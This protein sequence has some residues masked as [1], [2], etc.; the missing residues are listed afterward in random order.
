MLLELW[1]LLEA[2]FFLV[3]CVVQRGLCRSAPD[4][5]ALGTREARRETLERVLAV[6]ESLENYSFSDFVSGWFLGADAD[7][8][9]RG[10]LR[11][12]VAWALFAR[13]A[14]R[15]SAAEREECESLVDACA[16]LRARE[17]PCAPLEDADRGLPHV[18]MTIAPLHF[19]HRP[20]CFYVL[21][22]IKAQVAALVLS[23][24]GFERLREGNTTYWHRTAADAGVLMP[25]NGVPA[26]KNGVPT[27]KNGVSA[28]KNGASAPENGASAPKNGASAPE[29]RVPAAKSAPIVC[30]HGISSGIFFYLPLLLNLCRRRQAVIVEQPHVAMALDFRPPAREE[31]VAD[32]LKIL[33]RHRIAS[34]TFAGHSLGSVPVTWMAALAPQAVGQVLLLDPVCLLLSLPHVATNF[35][36]RRPSNARQALLYFGAASEIGVSNALRRHFHWYHNVLWLED[37]LLRDVP[38]T[39]ALAGRDEVAPAELIRGHCEAMGRKLRDLRVCYRRDHSHGQMLLDAAFQREII[40]TMVA[41][42]ARAKR[43]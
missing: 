20:L 31:L 13:R 6:V 33:H 43:V 35:L 15:L 40:A 16:L 14:D 18:D 1:L 12:F 7:A 29:S 2:L 10:D 5:P 28:P 39:V 21:V 11:R 4:P 42:E 22:A 17:G 37:P 34:A 8:V 32:V 24:F 3:I 25:K 23:L 30:F 19:L 38:I 26:P 9:G 27:P 41:Q 36:Y